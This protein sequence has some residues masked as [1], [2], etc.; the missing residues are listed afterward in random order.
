MLNKTILLFV[1]VCAFFAACSDGGVRDNPTDPGASKL[2]AA[3]SSADI[4]DQSS[5]SMT[6]NSSA[7]IYDQ[8]SA[9]MTANSSADN[10]V[11]SST[12]MTANS[13]ADIYDQSSA[14]M[15]AN[16]SADN[17]GQT[18]TSTVTSSYSSEVETPTRSIMYWSATRSAAKYQ[19]ITGFGDATDTEGWFYTFSDDNSSAVFASAYSSIGGAQVEV[20]DDCG[21]SICGSAHVSTD[22]YYSIG[23]NLKNEDKTSVNINSWGGFCM[24]YV[25][26]I[27]IIMLPDRNDA[28]TYEYDL[29]HLEFPSQQTKKTV[30]KTWS[31]YTVFGTFKGTTLTLSQSVLAVSSIRFDFRSSGA[32]NI[33]D[34]S[35]FF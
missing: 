10:Y 18:S 29:P 6:A 11:Q 13:S 31:E 9:S 26:A 3:N 28:A 4:Y 24:T 25:S 2:I 32:F 12:S 14:S 23:F 34:F 30:C 35:S 1:P 33:Y 20:V 16:S 19:V 27:P 7:D 17:Y 21:G 22:G 15:T 8:S 5:T